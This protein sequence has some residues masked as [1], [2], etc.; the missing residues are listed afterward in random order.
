MQSP[1]FLS[2]KVDTDNSLASSTADQLRSRQIELLY[3]QSVTVI[4]VMMAIAMV[5]TVA[6]WDLLDKSRLLTWL[7][8]L[9]LLSL[10]R[11][12]SA[13]RYKKQAPPVSHNAPWLH[14]YLVGLFLSACLWESLVFMVIMQLSLHDSAIL[15]LVL[16]GLAAGSSAYLIVLKR[17]YLTLLVPYLL[18]VGFYLVFTAHDSWHVVGWTIL[19]VFGFLIVTSI[20]PHQNLNQG[21][22]LH[23]EKL[24]L[25]EQLKQEKQ[26]IERLNI[27][28]N[29]DIDEI[30][31]KEQEL[32]QARDRAERMA[33]QMERLSSQDGLTGIAN[34]R[35]MDENL[36]VEWSRSLREQ[37]PLSMILCD[38]DRFKHYNDTYGHEAADSALQRIAEILDSVCRRGGDLAARYENDEFGIILPNTEHEHAVELAEQLRAEVEAL[39]IHHVQSNVPQVLTISFGVASAVAETELSAAVLIANADKALNAAKN[40][41]RNQVASSCQSMS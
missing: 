39:Q 10:V 21:L 31:E 33:R 26:E 2:Q 28:L 27:K 20:R 25:L 22:L 36:R 30:R 9:M 13:F 34:R 41:G 40:L 15:L 29:M 14:L 5:T 16:V 11:L 1:N 6:Y 37:T 23:L 18:P 19:I 38:V 32:M 4:P 24:S 3:D 12:T 17:A 35:R 7:V 8:A